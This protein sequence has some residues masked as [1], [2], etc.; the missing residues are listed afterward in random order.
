MF[1]SERLFQIKIP[2]YERVEADGTGLVRSRYKKGF[3]Y[4]GEATL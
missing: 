3:E 4:A 2:E 1:K